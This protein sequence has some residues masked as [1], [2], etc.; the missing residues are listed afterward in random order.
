MTLMKFF[1]PDWPDDDDETD[2]DAL[3][4]VAYES[5]IRQI[6]PQI[7]NDLLKVAGSYSLHD[8]LFQG[9]CLDYGRSE[10]LL[11]LICGDMVRGYSRA[12]LRY[13]GL[14]FPGC[15]IEELRRVASRDGTEIVDNEVDMVQAGTY[16]HR[17]RC[18]PDGEFAIQF[19][20]FSLDV[21]PRDDREF[22][23]WS[24]RFGVV[25]KGERAIF[26]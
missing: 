15:T 17:F 18:C 9:V 2:Y 21:I 16:E 25:E 3:A 5:H 4:W 19:T 20:G 14:R 13:A 11:S 23:P 6:A 7:P 8:G 1:L 24:P 22:V 12:V 26:E 10:L